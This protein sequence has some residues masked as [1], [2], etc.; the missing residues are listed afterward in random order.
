[1]RVHWEKLGILGSVY[2]L[3]GQ[4]FSDNEIAGRLTVSEDNGRRCVA[5][6]LRFGSHDNRAELIREAAPSPKSAQSSQERAAAQGGL[7]TSL[8][9]ATNLRIDQILESAVILGWNELLSGSESAIV[10]VEYATAPEPCLQYLKI[11]RPETKGK[12]DLICEYWI[13]AGSASLPKAGLTF[14]PGYHSV[15][16]EDT[17][18]S[19]MR[20]HDGI[21]DALFGETKLHMI[22]V[23]SPTPQERLSAARCISQAY[24]QRG[25]SFATAHAPELNNDAA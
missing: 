7:M 8:L 13:S 23:S 11:W 16:L 19:I 9:S 22:F 14:R 21:P 10:H 17:L 2:A 6:L 1:M 20:H 3:V 18:A 5:W 12:W 4:G 15:R 24:E 25:L